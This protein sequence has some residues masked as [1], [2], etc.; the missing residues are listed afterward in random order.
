MEGFSGSKF[1]KFPANF[2]E[3][4]ENLEKVK[5]RRNFRKIFM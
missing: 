5:A 4:L 1:E 2:G 3:M